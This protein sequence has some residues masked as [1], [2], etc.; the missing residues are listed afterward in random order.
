MQERNERESCLERLHT[1]Y[2]N[3][4]TLAEKLENERK[5]FA[6]MFGIIPGPAD[7]PCHDRFAADLE[8]LLK[9]CRAAGITPAETREALRYIYAA[10]TEHPQPRSSYWMLLAAH[11]LTLELIDGLDA[12]DAREM[13]DWYE[14]AF[15][16]RERV[17]V[18]NK[19]LKELKRKA[20]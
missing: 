14:S 11:A 16:R 18:Q 13:H 17:P 20:K 10:P 15:P 4:L 2:E 1:L 12:A 3:Y 7:D 8:N 6:G 5:P 19:V 9:G